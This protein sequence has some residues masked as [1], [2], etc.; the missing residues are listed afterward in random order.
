VGLAAEHKYQ[1]VLALCQLPPS[2][3]RQPAWLIAEHDHQV[4]NLSACEKHPDTLGHEKFDQKPA[5]ITRA[6]TGFVDLKRP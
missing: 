3:S 6:Q 4:I 1:T 5:V 2:Y